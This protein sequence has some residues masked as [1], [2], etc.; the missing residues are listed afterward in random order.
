VNKFEN[1]LFI[2]YFDQLAVSIKN[3]ITEL[4]QSLTHINAI[5]TEVLNMKNLCSQVMT[6]KKT[7][8]LSEVQLNS[9]NDLI[10]LK[11]VMR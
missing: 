2:K 1:A 7:F 9:P 4:Q 10:R 6:T 5:K 8:P 3:N 11:E